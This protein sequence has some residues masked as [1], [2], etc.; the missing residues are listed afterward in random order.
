M[1]L[2]SL[3]EGRNSWIVGSS[4]SLSSTRSLLHT[5]RTYALYHVPLISSCFPDVNVMLV[6]EPFYDFHSYTVHICVKYSTIERYAPRLPPPVAA[7]SLAF[8]RP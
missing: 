5:F 8:Q 3:L 7:F 6:F 1:D 2:V 4:L